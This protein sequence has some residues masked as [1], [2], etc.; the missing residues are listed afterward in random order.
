VPH[1][2]LGNWL[3]RSQHHFSVHFF[4]PNVSVVV[5]NASV[6]REKGNSLARVPEPPTQ[7][8]IDAKYQRTRA[9][10]RRRLPDEPPAVDE[11]CILVVACTKASV[12]IE[13]LSHSPVM[14]RKQG[15]AAYR[16]KQGAPA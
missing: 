7:T 2:K 13:M 12:H 15:D 5:C 10:K 6:A 14:R 1:T 11:G 16:R 9:A 4:N 8:R 3:A